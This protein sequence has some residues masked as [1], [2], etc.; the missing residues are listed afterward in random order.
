MKAKLAALMVLVI[1]MSSM[2]RELLERLPRPGDGTYGDNCISLLKNLLLWAFITPVGWVVLIMV[3]VGI[4]KGLYR[5]AKT[6]AT[7]DYSP[8]PEVD[9]RKR[10]LEELEK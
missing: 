2:A 6:V 8:I 7:T 3:V 5:T 9:K 1:Y 10:L 4:I